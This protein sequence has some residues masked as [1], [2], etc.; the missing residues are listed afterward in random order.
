MSIAFNPRPR[1][2]RFSPVACS[3]VLGA[4]GAVDLAPSWFAEEDALEVRIARHGAGTG[5]RC[6]PCCAGSPMPP[7]R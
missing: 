3:P 4:L 7:Q 2:P 5:G 1:R 6:R